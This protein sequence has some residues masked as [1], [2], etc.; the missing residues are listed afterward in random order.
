MN[1]KV[2]AVVYLGSK[3]NKEKLIF[4][5]YEKDNIDE[6]RFFLLVC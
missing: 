6:V 4:S 5:N 3:I 2:S 1:S